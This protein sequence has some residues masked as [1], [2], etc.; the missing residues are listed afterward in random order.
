MIAVLWFGPPGLQSST[1]GV[2]HT[3]RCHAPPRCMYV[4][5]FDSDD[6]EVVAEAVKHRRERDGTGVATAVNTPWGLIYTDDA[7][8][9]YQ[10]PKGAREDYVVHRT[11]RRIVHRYD[12]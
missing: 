2:Q 12:L 8:T 9:I 7:G 1:V 5:V 4:A 3:F 11:R 10:S 6:S